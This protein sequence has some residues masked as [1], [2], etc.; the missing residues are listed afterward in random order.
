MH[1]GLDNFEKIARFQSFD[2]SSFERKTVGLGESEIETLEHEI[3]EVLGE[4]ERT[5]RDL[6]KSPQSWQMERSHASFLYVLVRTTRPKIVVETGVADG[7]SSLV[8]LSALE[9]NQMGALTSFDVHDKVGALVPGRLS[10]RWNLIVL[11]SHHRGKAFRDHLATLKPIDVFLH[12][13]LHTYGHQSF[14]YRAAWKNLVDNGFLL[15][16]DADAT[17]AFIDFAYSRQLRPDILVG[18]RKVF[19]VLRKPPSSTGATF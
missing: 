3:H 2:A 15:S 8:I 13:A 18:C 14:E 12:D 10:H 16:D 1:P 4:S 7:F 11:P 5:R 6:L 19:G 9:K 17:F